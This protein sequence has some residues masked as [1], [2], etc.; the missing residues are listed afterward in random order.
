MAK[1]KK[2]AILGGAFDPVTRAHTQIAEYVL[3]HS[4][5]E[6]V[7]LMPSYKNT[8]KI[9]AQPEYRIAMCK[10]AVKDIENVSIFTYEIDNELEGI[11]VNV[12]KRLRTDT[13][14]KGFNFSMIIGI[15]QANSI[16][17]WV[18]Y[19]ALKKEVSFVVIPRKG[20]RKK[21][22]ID[23]FTEKPHVYLKRDAGIP[24]ISSTEIRFGA[25]YLYTDDYPGKEQF[26]QLLS[27]NLNSDVLLYIQDNNLYE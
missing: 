27:D 7:W 19:D 25:R 1:K 22:S 9:M 21:P 23:W 12:F 26:I 20:Y 6:E 8:T 17:T 13:E 15:D 24:K 10:K 2:V 11:T 18:D 5:F 3:K 4:D 16:D 14:Y